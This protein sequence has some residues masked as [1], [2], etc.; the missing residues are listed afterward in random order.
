MLCVCVCVCVCVTKK[1]TFY[2][3]KIEL[4]LIIPESKNLK[5]KDFIYWSKWEARWNLD[6]PLA[7]LGTRQNRRWLCGSEDSAPPAWLMVSFCRCH[8]L[9]LYQY[10]A[11]ALLSASSSR[12]ESS[13]SKDL[14]AC[15]L[16]CLEW[17][18]APWGHVTRV[19][20]MNTWQSRGAQRLNGL[21]KVTLSPV[22]RRSHITR[23]SPSHL[24]CP[25]S[26][27]KYPVGERC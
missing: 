2:N 12:C 27:S 4:L 22:R 25:S 6:L 19:C 9:K 21:P 20:W 10:C 18:L 8:H 23:S 1:E 7:L 24:A 26:P 3:W 16:P 13:E 15:S 14:L 5:L 11:R 17:R